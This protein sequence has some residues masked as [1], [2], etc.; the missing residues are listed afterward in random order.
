MYRTHLLW[1]R[2]PVSPS[3]RRQTPRYKYQTTKLF[4]LRK[5]SALA[6]EC[7]RVATAKTVEA[8]SRRRRESVADETAG[9]LFNF[10]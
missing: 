9:G 7:A 6:P 1:M 10:I 5:E 3:G 2:T 4:P 8:T